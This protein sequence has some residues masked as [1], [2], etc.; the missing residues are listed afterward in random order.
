RLLVRV[1]TGRPKNERQLVAAIAPSIWELDDV[2]RG[3]LCQLFGG[4]SK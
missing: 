2:K 1:A 4:N 3:I